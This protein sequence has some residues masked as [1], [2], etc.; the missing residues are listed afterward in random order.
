[1]PKIVRRTQI[2]LPAITVVKAAMYSVIVRSPTAG[3]ATSVVRLVI[4]PETVQIGLKMIANATLAEKQDIYLV[5][6]PMQRKNTKVLLPAT[7]ATKKGTW[8]VTA[9]RAM[10][11][12]AVT[13]VT[14]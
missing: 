1:M 14:S 5:T 9:P 4:L 12:S 13:S 8:L 10:A 3:L 7:G 6:V 2:P 11:I